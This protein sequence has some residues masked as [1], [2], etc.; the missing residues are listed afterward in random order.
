MEVRLLIWRQQ[1]QSASWSWQAIVGPP[2]LQK[3]GKLSNSAELQPDPAFSES[4]CELKDPK[5]LLLSQNRRVPNLQHPADMLLHSSYRSSQWSSPPNPPTQQIKKTELLLEKR[6][7]VCPKQLCSFMHLFNFGIETN[8]SN[9]GNAAW[10]SNWADVVD[11]ATA[12]FFLSFQSTDNQ[13]VRKSTSRV[14]TAHI[15]TRI[16]T[17][18]KPPPLQKP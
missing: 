18:R 1:Q 7:K 10:S 4:E 9:C 6:K 5:P 12:S 2:R 17:T 14:H 11:L 3:K 15:H 16:T 8:K 13:R